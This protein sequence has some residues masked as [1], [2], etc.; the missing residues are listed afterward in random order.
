M[1]RQLALLGALFLTCGS[2]GTIVNAAPAPQVAASSATAIVKGTVVDE[3]G[4]PVIGASIQEVG[5]TRGTTTDVNGK[6][7]LRAGAG[8]KLQISYIGY[9]TQNVK[10]TDGMTVKLATDNALLDEVVVVGYG[11][12]KKKDATGSVTAIKPDEMN[13]GLVTNAQDM[14][15]GKIAGVQVTDNGG[16]PGGGASIRIRGG[17]SLSASNDPLIV[18]DGVPGGNLTN[19]N[20]NDIESIDILK[21]GAASA[22][23]G[24][25]GSNGV[26]LINTK[27][28]S[29]D[30]SF[31]TYYNA[32]VS[33]NVMVKD[34]DMLSAQEFRDLKC[35]A[36]M[37]EDLG[38]N[39]DWMKEISRVGFTHQHTLTLSGGNANN[40]FR[41]FGNIF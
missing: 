29:K 25:R 7:S 18:I 24:T 26:V 10:A 32:L 28:G 8:A 41:I 34:L 5:T 11:T 40:N 21:D 16:T 36:G 4:E 1:K 9:K 13:K 22:I 20:P 12:V 23:Y 19:V 39:A 30:G 27:K 17:S 15:S 2:V 31:H 3:K 35:S 37:A 14:L 33:A 38:G 6:F